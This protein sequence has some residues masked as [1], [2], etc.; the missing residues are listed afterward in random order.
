MENGIADDAR[1]S[2]RRYCSQH[3]SNLVV[4]GSSGTEA[5]VYYCG[6]PVISY[7]GPRVRFGAQTKSFRRSGD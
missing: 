6:I 2:G 4:L 5:G 7:P 3:E 1:P